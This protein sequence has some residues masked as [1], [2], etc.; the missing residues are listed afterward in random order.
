[1]STENIIGPIPQINDIF[2][3]VSASISPTVKP[4]I[5]PPQ[6]NPVLAY[7]GLKAKGRGQFKISEYDLGEIGRVE[8][9]DSYVR[10]AFDKK[11]A[12]MFKEGWDLEGKNL[13]AI[14]YIKIRLAQIANASKNPTNKFLREIGSSILRKSNAFVVKKRKTSASGGKVRKAPGSQR[15]ITPIAAYFLAPAE[16]LNFQMSS[17]RIASWRQRMPNGDTRDFKPEDIVHFYFNRK[18]GFVF[19]TPTL[20]PVIDDVRALRKIEENIELLVYQHLFPL[21]H[22]KVGTEKLPAT[23]TDEGEREIDVV[24]REIQFM[25]T[26]GGIVTPE[27]HEITAIGAEGRAIRAESYLDYFKK[28][29]FSGLGISAVDM[30]DGEC[31]SNDTQTLTENGWKFHWNIDH[32][33]E[34]IGTYNPETQELEYHLAHSKYEGFYEGDMILFKGKHVDLKVSPNHEMWVLNRYSGK[35]KKVYASELL[36]SKEEFCFIDTFSSFQG[37]SSDV[38]IGDESIDS[39]VWMEFLGWWLSEGSVDQYNA[40]KCRYRTIITQK[41]IRDLSSIRSCLSKL[42][43]NYREQIDKRDGTVSFIIYSKALYKILEPLGLS[44]LRFIPKE[45]LEYNSSHCSILLDS[46]MRGDGTWDK[47]KG[48]KSGVYYTASKQLADDVQIL[49][50]QAGYSAKIVSRKNTGYSDGIIYRVLIT[51][52][53][54]NY[55]ILTADHVSVERYSNIIYCYNVPNH[56]FVTRRNNIVSI[57]G[58][59]ANRATADN[60]SR[61]LVDAVKDLQQVVE[62]FFN[63]FI[64]KELLLESTF[65]TSAL[66]EEN[67]VFLKFREVDVELKV[68]KEAHA[69]DLFNKDVIT[70]DEARRKMGLEPIK[71]PTPDEVQAGQDGADRFPE[72]N[73]LRWKLFKEPELLIQALDEAYSPFAQAVAKNNSIS[74]TGSDI[75]AS[76]EAKVKQ[77]S[78]LEGA[79]AKA[80]APAATPSTPIKDGLIA[81]T[82]NEVRETVIGGIGSR[83]RFEADWAS[84]LIRTQMLSTTD[85]LVSQQLMAYRDGYAVKGNIQDADFFMRSSLARTL[86]RSRMETYVTRLTENTISSL[87]RNISIEMGEEASKSKARAVFDTLQFRAGFIEDVEFRKAKALGIIHAALDSGVTGVLSTTPSSPDSCSSCSS[88]SRDFHSITFITLEDLAPHHANCHCKNVIGDS[89]LKIENSISQ[90]TFASSPEYDKTVKF[91]NDSSDEEEAD[92]KDFFKKGRGAFNRCVS[93]QIATMKSK[94]QKPDKALAEAACSFHLVEELDEDLDEEFEGEE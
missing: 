79:K 43:F 24:R 89:P 71:L 41:K 87:R 29:V 14:N 49:S 69:A 34:R 78:E 12:L 81:E 42:P 1:M 67:L 59:T 26:E 77:E 18:D 7:Q 63:E 6:A 45:F 53:D 66:D 39:E 19:G 4:A 16:T 57:Q 35:H 33:K 86:L 84:S 23:L 54:K 61:N 27:R 58:N 15:L 65:G 82:F 50:L 28:R 5:I 91:L 13:K 70:L 31:Y 25:P 17:N 73:N 46:L 55:R 22:Y 47:R 62:T 74:A 32:L 37:S 2:P 76:G 94:G 52:R 44:P 68:K 60:M 36:K 93:K 56:L 10:Q 90:V 9:T 72:W 20:T 30:G 51:K 64:I 88:K 92:P 3:G 83:Q 38:V 21:F 40:S 80:R 11:L 8:D 75:S 85:K 48:R